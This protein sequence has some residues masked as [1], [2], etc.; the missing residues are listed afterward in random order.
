MRWGITIIATLAVVA[1]AVLAFLTMPEVNLPSPSTPA[2]TGPSLSNPSALGERAPEPTPTPTP[3]PT[4]Q[5]NRSSMSMQSDPTR[6]S[7]RFT[8]NPDG[9]VLD[10][11]TGFI[12][13]QED[14]QSDMSFTEAEAYCAQLSLGG[15]D[16]WQLPPISLLRS[17]IAAC[18]ASSFGGRCPIRDQTPARDAQCAGCEMMRGPGPMGSY[19]HPLFRFSGSLMET[20]S[21]TKSAPPNPLVATLA[22][23]TAAIRMTPPDQR[24]RVRCVVRS[25]RAD[26]G[27]KMETSLSDS[28]K[29]QRP[30]LEECYQKALAKQPG[31]RGR[32][33]VDF[34]INP[35]GRAADPKVTTRTVENET[36]ETCVLETVRNTLFTPPAGGTTVTVSHPFTFPLPAP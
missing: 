30:A 3:D 7:D 25:D 10:T 15:M 21:S 27:K 33:V 18:T 29:E 13:M 34:S 26:L 31:L 2:V 35:A 36:L 24:L 20:W 11:K 12:W 6:N 17:V 4:P 5:N 14:A 16:N 28:F 22:F 8:A 9:T 19:L 32:L 23:Q 1:L